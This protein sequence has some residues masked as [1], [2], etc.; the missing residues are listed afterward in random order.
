[1]SR[2]FNATLLYGDWLYIGGAFDAGPSQL[3]ASGVR[4]VL[5]VKGGALPKAGNSPNP[6]RYK[7]KPLCDYGR[8]DLTKAVGG[9]CRFL[10]RAREAKEKAL[11]HCR[12]GVNRSATAVLAY[13]LLEEGIPL[14]DAA[15]LLLRAHPRALPHPLYLEQ[16]VKMD[17]T[18]SCD[19]AQLTALFPPLG[20]PS[21]RCVLAMQ[22]RFSGRETPADGRPAFA[23]PV[24]LQEEY[25]RLR[26]LWNGMLERYPAAFVM[27]SGRADAADAV[28]MARE[29]GQS[30]CVRG[31]GHS[32]TGL[33]GRTGQVVLDMRQLRQVWYEEEARLAHVGGG[34]TWRDVDRELSGLGRACVAGLVGHT[35]VAGLC[36]G[37]GMGW[38]S[39]LHGLSCDNL[40]GIEGVAG[41]GELVTVRPADA[42]SSDLMFGM[43]GAGGNFAAVT[44]L[45]MRTH[46]VFCALLSLLEWHNPEQAVHRDA[47][48][49]AYQSYCT[50]PELPRWAV[51]YAWLSQ[52]VTLLAFV[53]IVEEEA[54]F[55]ERQRAHLSRIS[56]FASKACPTLD[57]PLSI[58]SMAEL[59]SVCYSIHCTLLFLFFC[60]CF[61]II[62]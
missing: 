34:A 25:Q 57:H 54:Q 61:L 62:D 51:C 2:S 21:S 9:I 12:M 6:V 41:T 22:R 28:A 26:K 49:Q 56:A 11:V 35:G 39:R 37:G 40:L 43:R 24:V 50:A 32:V 1:M 7:C 29:H 36:L 31:G 47:V 42:E 14:R 59:N 3:E 45:S 18:R 27:P 19:L 55:P 8:S 17:A 48:M 53:D 46:P 20:S 5:N 44:R 4:W 23:S 15:L 52:H 16:L 60:C 30:L 38:L 10:R 33:S 13:L 58:L